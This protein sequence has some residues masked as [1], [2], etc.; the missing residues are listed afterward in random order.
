MIFVFF[1]AVLFGLVHPGSKI[2]MDRGVGLLSFC[3]L[4]TSVRLIF[5]IPLILYSGKWKIKS[6]RQFILL[7]FLGIVGAILQYTEFFAISKKVPVS[8]VTFLVYT[9][10]IWT[11]ILNRWINAE[12]LTL[13]SLLKLFSAFIGVLLIAG[14]NLTNNTDF[15]LLLPPLF[16]ALMISLWIIIT[17]IAR[18]AECSSYTI[19]FYYDLFTFLFLAIAINAS[20]ENY[21]LSNEIK[22]ITATPFLG[23][24]I[25]FYS[26]F[27]G[28][29][30]NLLFYYG[31]KFVSAVTAGFI[32]LLEPVI[33]ASA[34]KLIWGD[35]LNTYFFLGAFLILCTNIPS[36]SFFKKPRT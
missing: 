16:S 8:L 21:F 10:P 18:R 3:L 27:I 22:L 30:P 28:L 14:A 11:I 5:Q 6:K 12:R 17:S 29:A 7:F 15:I 34:G 9:H 13:A 25:I 1:A 32:L 23:G 24:A 35:P 19:S 31:S 26:I 4:Y 20:T 36:F 2:I 33:S